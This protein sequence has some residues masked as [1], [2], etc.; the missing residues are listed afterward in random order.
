VALVVAAV[1]EKQA[2]LVQQ[3]KVMQV[4]QQ[5]QVKQVAAVVHHKLQL[6]LLVEME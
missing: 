3:M 6:R 4:L 2:H 5:L 1:L